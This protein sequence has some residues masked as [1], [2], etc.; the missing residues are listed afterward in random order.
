[1]ESSKPV[2]NQS[3]TQTFVPRKLDGIKL[4]DKRYIVTRQRNVN[5]LAENGCRPTPTTLQ[6]TETNFPSYNKYVLIG[7][8]TLCS[9]NLPCAKVK[10]QFR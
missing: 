3:G 6:E 2:Y 8:P 1:L 9:S 7:L 5:S 4:T 10:A